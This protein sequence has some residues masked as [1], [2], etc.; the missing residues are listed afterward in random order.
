MA[1]AGRRQCL[2][3]AAAHGPSR[4]R[5]KAPRRPLLP[6]AGKGRERR[7]TAALRARVDDPD[8]GEGD[9]GT[10]VLRSTSRRARVRCRRLLSI[11]M[12]GTLWVVVRPPLAV[13]LL[14]RSR[15]LSFWIWNA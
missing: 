14:G 2:W 12:V 13:S 7:G 1:N 8:G 11:W 10:N 15:R 3:A 9:R 6:T 5:R 4:A